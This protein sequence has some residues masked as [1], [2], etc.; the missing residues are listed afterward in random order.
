VIRVSVTR[1]HGQYYACAEDFGIAGMGP[2]RGAALR[3]LAGL[4]DAY[5]RSYFAEGRSY[6][7][8][9]RRTT[10]PYP[11]DAIVAGVR[12][13]LERL[14]GR[15]SDLVLPAALHPPGPAL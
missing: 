9:L 6:E 5:L 11:W 12:H 4:V 7:D 8:A 14:V 15:S 2:T 13:A 10:G 1:D 3:D